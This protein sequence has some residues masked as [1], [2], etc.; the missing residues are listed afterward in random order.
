MIRTIVLGLATI[1]FIMAS[2]QESHEITFTNK[3]VY[4]LTRI[5]ALSSDMQSIAVVM[6]L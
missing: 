5:T 2:A 3:Y 4:T 1:P 6:G